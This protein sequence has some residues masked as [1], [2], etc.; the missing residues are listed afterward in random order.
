MPAKPVPIIPLLR[1]IALAIGAAL[2]GA[3]SGYNMAP[4]CPPCLQLP[5]PSPV[6]LPAPLPV[7]EEAPAP[8][9]ALLSV[10]E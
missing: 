10:P 2:A 3:G 9:E 4:S 7:L 5:V 8:L 6:P 1:V